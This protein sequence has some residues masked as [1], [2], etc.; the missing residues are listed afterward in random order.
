M[1][2]VLGLNP[3]FGGFNYHDPSACLVIDGRVV[4]A[5]EEERLNRQKGAPGVFP[6]LAVKACLD[7]AGLTLTDLDAVAIGYSSKAWLERL[8]L[9]TDRLRDA[10]GLRELAAMPARAVRPDRA[11]ELL[12]DSVRGFTDLLHRSSLFG[13]EERA[14]ERIAEYLPGLTA[15]IRFVQH[16]KAHAASAVYP[17][18]FRDPVALVH[19]GLGELECGSAWAAGPGARLARL[20][21]TDLPN[22]LGYFY[23]A[24]TEFLG[25]KG[26][27]GEGKTMALAPYGRPDPAA[28][29]ALEAL[30]TADDDGYDVTPLVLPNLGAQLSLDTKRAVAHLAELFKTP[31]RGADDEITQHHKNIA[32]AAQNFL[33]RA[34]TGH[35]RRLARSHGAP[36]DLC[37]AGGV[38]L[39]CKLNMAL[40]EMPEV[41]RLYVPGPGS[42]TGLALGAA[43]QVAAETGDDVRRP[44]PHLALGPA[45]DVPPDTYLTQL[46]IPFERPADVATA[47]AGHIADGKVVMWYQGR[48]EFGPRALGSRSIL[49]DPRRED[50]RV[51]VNE[52]VKHRELWRPFGPSVLAEH[53]HE[54][55]QDVRDGDPAPYMIVAYR[56]REE[57]AA[58]IPAV[59]HS[60][61]GTTRPQFVEADARPEYHA[62]ISAFHRLTGVPLVLNTSFN[63]KGEPLVQTVRDAVRHF[64]SSAADVLVLD[65]CVVTKGAP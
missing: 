34:V 4:S 37:F 51:L 45:A 23:A 38:A 22:S 62:V 43:L 20:A 35:V 46:K 9:E 21:Q 8:P 11:R 27:E 24:V 13:T 36:L 6:A 41:R 29:G 50:M 2:V 55:L 32:W 16:H 60:A 19:D 61:D 12:A 49:A 15:P 14:A 65:G 31:P 58:R 63:D 10:A 5:V 3:G 40:R 64:Y 33:E 25:F 18:G 47:V 54:V 26:W 56:V 42:D 39:N 44:L 59:V 17:S 30:L 53:A 57:W 7:A 1:S 48:S 28:G 52:V